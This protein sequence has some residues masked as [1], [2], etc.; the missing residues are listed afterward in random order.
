MRGQIVV[1][2]L[3]YNARKTCPH[4][5]RIARP[6][7]SRPPSS[8]DLEAGHAWFRCRRCG[9]QF[10]APVI[11]SIPIEDAMRESHEGPGMSLTA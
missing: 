2:G 4:C 10:M 5:N 3:H 9:H 6:D 1:G 8:A 11:V 7:P